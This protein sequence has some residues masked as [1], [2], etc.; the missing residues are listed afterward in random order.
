[1]MKTGTEQH[2]QEIAAFD[3]VVPHVAVG[4]TE[5]KDGVGLYLEDIK[6]YPILSREEEAGLSKVIEA[7]T[8]A[9]ILL[10]LR[11]EA[12]R[13]DVKDRLHGIMAEKAKKMRRSKPAA[14]YD[15]GV[16]SQEVRT[17]TIEAWEKR[18]L[19]L[20][21]TEAH[22]LVMLQEQGRQAKDWFVRCNL[23]LVVSIAKRYKECG[24]PL[25][26][27]IQEG[28]RGLIHA[29][30]KF[31]HT[32]GYK[33]STYATHWIKQAI[34]VGVANTAEPIRIPTHAKEWL[35]RA[36]RIRNKIMT[37]L[38][39]EPTDQEVADKL[40]VSVEHLNDMRKNK[41][42]VFSLN[43][44]LDPTDPHSNEV[45]DIETDPLQIDVA[46]MVLGGLKRQAIEAMIAGLPERY[47][48]VLRMRYGF[49]GHEYTYE[50]IAAE[51]GI[52]K[53]GARMLER[54]IIEKVANSSSA[55][56]LWD[57]Y[58]D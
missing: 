17:A 19:S 18:A 36:Q 20:T 14:T 32:Q 41:R 29:V 56:D 39:R 21:D 6:D 2:P 33:F 15:S 9:D 42:R 5:M 48:T 54:R 4:H 37:E 43:A 1:M 28:N 44:A 45:H 50:E 49:D 52:T 38:G 51:L 47:Q 23:R 58:Q 7:G 26:D 31:D 40:N 25:L 13:D 22:E 46:D 27:L 53:Q 10:S 8:T 3:E 16:A 35:D 34:S 11:D 12:Q 30:D 57:L 55:R 24:L